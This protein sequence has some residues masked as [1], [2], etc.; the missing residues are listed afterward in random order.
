[1][2]LMRASLR[3]DSLKIEKLNTKLN[4]K[5]ARVTQDFRVIFT[6]SGN[7]ILLVY[8]APHDDAYLWAQGRSKAFDADSAKPISKYFEQA[9]R[10]T[11]PAAEINP[12]PPKTSVKEKTAAAVV[13]KPEQP[14]TQIA[15]ASKSSSKY[16]LLKTFALCSLFFLMGVITGIIM[17]YII[18]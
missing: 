16:R 1:M 17:F 12:L 9:V 8:I 4:P 15:P 13:S 2:R 11:V 10:P 18:L 5:S 14:K 3:S 7:T 6:Q